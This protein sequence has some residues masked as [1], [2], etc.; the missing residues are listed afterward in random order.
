MAYQQENFI[1]RQVEQWALAPEDQEAIVDF[2][3][4]SGID[5]PGDGADDGVAVDTFDAGGSAEPVAI[6]AT[7]DVASITSGGVYTSTGNNLVFHVDTDE[8]VTINGVSVPGGS[9]AIVSGAGDDDISIVSGAGG[10]G[11]A[12][13]AAASD[14]AGAG[15]AGTGLV[16][17][18]AGDDSVTGGA[19]DD[20]ISGGD[21]DDSIMAGDGDD[22]VSGGAGDDSIDGGDG[23]DMA[24]AGGDRD[25]MSV[26]AG[27]SG[28]LV[29][30]GTGAGSLFQNIEYLA[31]DDGG[32][33]LALADDAEGAVARL[34]EAILDRAADAGGLQFWLEVSE[35]DASLAHVASRFLQSKEFIEGDPDGL[36]DE[37]FVEMLYLQ[38]L[39]R[40]ADGGGLEFWT[41][42]LQADGGPSRAELAALFVTS[43]EGEDAFD[44]INIVSDSDLG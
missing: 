5:A 8:D 31:F 4:R 32:V 1:D 14:G 24:M 16:M 7:V 21:G 33:E 41:G 34:Y 26:E 17:A 19:G 20:S 25:T 28:L 29:S 37:E 15:E 36:S 11:A 43:E 10:A 3:A 2:L 12:V 30:D 18:G 44:Y 22:T 27:A 38:G 39:G 42:A 9:V 13:I 35:D 23:F 6:P 40:E